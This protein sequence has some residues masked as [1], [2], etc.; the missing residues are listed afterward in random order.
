MFCFRSACAVD[1]FVCVCV[2]QN[3]LDKGR[4]FECERRK[5]SFGLVVAVAEHVATSHASVHGAPTNPISDVSGGNAALV[6]FKAS[7]TGAKKDSIFNKEGV[8][9]IMEMKT[10]YEMD[11]ISNTSDIDSIL[12]K[13]DFSESKKDELFINLLNYI[14]TKIC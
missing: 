8:K 6:S 4:S 10:K 1:T 3:P 13:M 5:S 2:S 9:Q 12:K 14:A 7:Y 11:E